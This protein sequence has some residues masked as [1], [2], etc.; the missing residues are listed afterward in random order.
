M[1]PIQSGI[2]EKFMYKTRLRFRDLLPADIRS[3]HFTYHLKELIKQGYLKNGKVFYTLTN[4]GKDFIG[5]LDEQT[6]DIE[7]NPKVSVLIY[8]RKKDKKE[9]Y[10]YLMHKRLKQP[11]F[12]KVGNITGK[13]KYGESLKDAAKRELLEETGLS[14]RVKLNHFYHKIRKTQKGET[15]Q[16]SIF[17]VFLVEEPKGRL[18]QPKDGKFFWIELGNL[19]KRKDL[20]D[21]V[22]ENFKKLLDDSYFFVE[23]IDRAQGY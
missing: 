7:K 16:D 15:V 18:V 1:H 21:D 20:F 14:G 5:S 9:R 10:E 17:A 13:V 6:L 3:E 22:K 2:L 11:Y 19:Y 23:D 8:I 12:G 4:K